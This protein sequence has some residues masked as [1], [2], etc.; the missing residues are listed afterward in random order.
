MMYQ[1]LRFSM[2]LRHTLQHSRYENTPNWY[3]ELRII[4]LQT[5]SRSFWL[6]DRTTCCR[7]R[8]T[9][10]L[11]VDIIAFQVRGRQDNGNDSEKRQRQWR[12]TTTA[13]ED[14]LRGKNDTEN[15]AQ[16]TIAKAPLSES[17]KAKNKLIIFSSSLLSEFPIFQSNWNLKIGA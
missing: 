11:L 2:Y 10:S 13:T 7:T 17:K 14:S 8:W 15:I 5:S 9:G 6:I 4:A 12:K 1:K 3:K 16:S